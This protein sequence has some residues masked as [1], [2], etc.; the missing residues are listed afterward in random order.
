MILNV[1]FRQ[2]DMTPALDHRISKKFLKLKKFLKNPNAKTKLTCYVQK[3]QH[4]TEVEIFDGPR[5]YYA[6]ANENNLYKTFDTVISK[7]MRQ[8]PSRHHKNKSKKGVVMNE[9]VV[10]S[11]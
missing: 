7:I 11:S 9:N 8:F 6:K 5:V 4:T 3:G 1:N 10:R 2:L